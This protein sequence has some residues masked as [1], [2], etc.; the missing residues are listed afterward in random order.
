[1]NDELFDDYKIDINRVY[2]GGY[3][4]GAVT[5]I[6]AAYLNEYEEVPEFLYGDY[7]MTVG[8]TP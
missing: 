1:M 2:A 3:S 8:N 5:A 4:A 7:R 6:N